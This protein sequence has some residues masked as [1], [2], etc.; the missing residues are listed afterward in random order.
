MIGTDRLLDLYHET[1]RAHFKHTRTSNYWSA[2]A[3]GYCMRRQYLSRLGVPSTR[4][5]DG[6]TLRTFAMGNDVERH[7]KRAWQRAGLLVAEEIPVRDDELQVTGRIDAIVGG[8]VQPIESIP[9]SLLMSWSP[10]YIAMLADFRVRI[11]AELARLAE[12]GEWD[13]EGYAAIETKSTKEFSLQAMFK[14]G[15]NQ[16]H[17]LQAAAYKL[18]VRRNPSLIP[19]P[20]ESVRW[21]VEPISKSNFA[22]LRFAVMPK[23][24]AEVERRLEILNNAWATQTPPPCTCTGK[25]AIF[26]GKE[27]TYC[28]YG[29]GSKDSCCDVATG[30]EDVGEGVQSPGGRTS[31]RGVA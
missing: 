11:A 19:V 7:V 30:A 26:G 23:H 18:I 2:S 22:F 31:E 15:P 28:D 20:F 5:L 6:K 25:D 27:W 21:L 8:R 13:P 4:E 1:E 17:I 10:E 9:A 14:N 29:T 24:V 16:T 3:L 12:E